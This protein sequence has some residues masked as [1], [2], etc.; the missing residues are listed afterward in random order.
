MK[1][2]INLSNNH[3]HNYGDNV[4]DL[5]AVCQSYCSDHEDR[6]LIEWFFALLHNKM[7]FT[8]TL[9]ITVAEQTLACGDWCIVRT[10]KRLFLYA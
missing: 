1:K 3:E 10:D 4:S 7:D 5:V 6:Y 2:V 9:P 8:D